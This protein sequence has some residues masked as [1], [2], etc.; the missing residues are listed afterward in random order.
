MGCKEKIGPK[1]MCFFNINFFFSFSFSFLLLWHP[2]SM[3]QPAST[4]LPSLANL[5]WG[6]GFLFPTPPS[7]LAN[8]SRGWVFHHPPSTLKANAL[9][10][11]P[12]GQCRPTAA[13]EGQCRPTAA[14]AGQH[15]LTARPT[16]ANDSQWRP[17][18]THSSQRWDEGQHVAQGL[19]FHDEEFYTVC[20]FWICISY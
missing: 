7:S 4:P 16:A 2:A 14:N 17:T 1:G 8:T 15:R 9:T 18:W 13:K 20:T 6:W 10:I 11:N 12:E 19:C 3:N 5:S